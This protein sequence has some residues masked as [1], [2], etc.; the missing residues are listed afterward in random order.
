M[1]K[2]FGLKDLPSF[3][4]RHPNGHGKVGINIM[5]GT[6]GRSYIIIKNDIGNIFKV[7]DQAKTYFKVIS[8]RSGKMILRMRHFQRAAIAK[9]KNKKS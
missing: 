7:A 4:S 8:A 5:Q 6:G 2:N 3:I 1:P 9:F